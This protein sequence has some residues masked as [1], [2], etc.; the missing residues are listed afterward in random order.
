ML[1]ST[2]LQLY[3][4]LAGSAGLNAERSD[5][6]GQPADQVRLTRTIVAPACT[7][8]GIQ[9]AVAAGVPAGQGGVGA[10]PERETEGASFPSGGAQTEQH[11]QDNKQTK[12]HAAG[13]ISSR[14]GDA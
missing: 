8:L 10:E 11:D 9:T 7:A 14:G 4:G 6:V 12:T 2:A 13:V 1:A 5:R 3:P